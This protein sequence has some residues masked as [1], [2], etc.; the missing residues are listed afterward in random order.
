MYE[1]F[2]SSSLSPY[3][4]YH[5][6]PRA[7]ELFGKLKAVRPSRASLIRSFVRSSIHS[8][9]FASNFHPSQDAAGA[10]RGAV[11]IRGPSAA[12][13]PDTQHQEEDGG[14]GARVAAA[15]AAA[16]QGD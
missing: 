2:M 15:A 10:P 4:A 6:N 13:G 12:A 11:Q 7:S 9:H 16:G 5:Q 8:F 3:P 14:D 1:R